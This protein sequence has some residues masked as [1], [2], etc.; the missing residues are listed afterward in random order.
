MAVLAV[1]RPRDVMQ[2]RRLIAAAAP[3]DD[4]LLA[5]PAVPLRSATVN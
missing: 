1:D 3:V 5:D 2:G 4:G